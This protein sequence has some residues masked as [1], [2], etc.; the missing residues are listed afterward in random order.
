MNLCDAAA[1]CLCVSLVVAP[2]GALCASRSISCERSLKRLAAANEG[3]EIL[4]GFSEDC[5]LG[6]TTAELISVYGPS[7]REHECLEPLDT[8]RSLEIHTGTS[9]ISYYAGGSR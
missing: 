8:V 3:K 5:A 6:K 7:V 2:L 1:A 4:N 9:T